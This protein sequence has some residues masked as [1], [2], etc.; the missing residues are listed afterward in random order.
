MA[1]RLHKI[2]HFELFWLLVD[3]WLPDGS[4]LLPCRRMAPNKFML[5]RFQSFWANGSQ[6][7]QEVSVCPVLVSCGPIALRW[8][9]PNSVGMV[10]V[11]IVWVAVVRI[12]LVW[13]RS[14]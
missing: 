9:W 11:D 5:I 14:G 10:W 7:I 4:V 2:A 1:P 6:M 12:R 13:V 8:L 3:K